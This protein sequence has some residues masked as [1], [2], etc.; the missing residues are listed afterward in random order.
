LEKARLNEDVLAGALFIA[1]GVFGFW[2]SRELSAG[3]ASAMGP[4]DLPRALCACMIGLGLII[5]VKGL[6]QSVPLKAWHLRPLLAVL[7]SI[8]VFAF[9]LPRAG[10]FIA[11]FLTVVVAAFAA[12]DIHWRELLILAVALAVVVVLVFVYGLGLPIN[13]WP[14]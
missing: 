12:K 5:A 6:K 8:F 2:I 11:S 7:A 4:G 3:T 13:P 10:L 1:C 14:V 9:L